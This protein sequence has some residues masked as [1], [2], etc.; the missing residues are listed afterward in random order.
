MRRLDKLFYC[1]LKS[2]PLMQSSNLQ[3]EALICWRVFA[4]FALMGLFFL[5]YAYIHQHSIRKYDC[6]PLCKPL[7]VATLV[8][9]AANFKAACSRI[10]RVG[11]RKRYSER[12]IRVRS[13]QL[14]ND[15]MIKTMHPKLAPISLF[16][17][18]F[19]EKHIAKFLLKY[20]E[21]LWNY[22]SHANKT[23]LLYK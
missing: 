11:G 10:A 5:L 3:I 14:R 2:Y 18:G 23:S 12:K 9:Q 7:Y 4:I 1:N 19:D 20:S 8:R 16:A 13:H 17:V 6:T 15:A 22:N 21:I